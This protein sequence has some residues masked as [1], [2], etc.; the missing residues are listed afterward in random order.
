MYGAI[1][2]TYSTRKNRRR[3]R[4]GGRLA[5]IATLALLITTSLMNTQAE[6]SCSGKAIHSGDNIASL[7]NNGASGTTF[8][9][10]P[11]TYRPSATLR[12]KDNVTLVGTGLSR[13]GVLIT[14]GKLELI[15]NASGV[16]GLVLRNLAISGAINRCPRRNCGATGDG[17]HGGTNVRATNVHVYGNGR[18]GFS[19]TIGLT[20]T[21]SRLDHNGAVKYGDMDGVSAGVKSSAPLTVTNS[22]VDHNYGNGIWCDMQCGALTVKGNTVTY[23][24]STGI[25]DEISQGPAVIA[26]NTVKYNNAANEAGHGGIGIIDSKNVA[27]YGN[28]VDANK[29]SGI[30]AREDKRANCGPPSYVC[31]FQLN[32]VSIHNNFLHGDVLAGCSTYGVKCY[33]NTLK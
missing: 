17:V 15:I 16:Q 27:V 19:S 6:A 9:I 1:Q 28:T 14:T 5:M 32:N 25:H 26:N 13:D 33:S 21:G 31:G 24:L 22:V 20:I 12:P 8:C 7:I 3:G 23:N 2:E 10:A 18:S 4:I 29:G 11:G 30:S